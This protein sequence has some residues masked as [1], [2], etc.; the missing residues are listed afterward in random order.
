MADIRTVIA[1]TGEDDRY[2]GVRDEG[3]ARARKAGATLILYD[4]DA[5]RDP[6][7]SPLPTEWSA[8]GE[9]D[10]VGSRLAPDEL[11]AAGRATIA[12]QVREARAAGLDAWGWLPDRD[13][14]DTL[15]TYAQ[16]QPGPFVVVPRDKADLLGDLAVDAARHERSR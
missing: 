14:G 15:R 8:E 11:D 9:E 1:V 4:V 16:K 13:D 7:E 3:I 5:G 6:L 12:S 10:A 2:A